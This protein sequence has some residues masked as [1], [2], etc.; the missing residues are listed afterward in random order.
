MSTTPFALLDL[1]KEIA[2][3]GQESHLRSAVSRA[4]YAGYHGC[5]EW[6]ESL[7]GVASISGQEG[8]VP[9]Q[10]INQLQNPAPEVKCQETRMLSK[11]LSTRL[12]VFRVQRVKADYFLDEA[13]PFDMWSANAIAGV[14]L[15]LAQMQQ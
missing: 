12:Q 15:M 13:K 8:G 1:A 9:Q 6:Y 2:A 3:G 5:K 7:P 10:L 11:K 14:E 4:Y